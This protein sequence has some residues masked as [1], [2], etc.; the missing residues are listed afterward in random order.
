MSLDDL[1][2]EL[3][4]VGVPQSALNIDMN[5]HT[6]VESLTFSFDKD[7]KKLPIVMIQN[8]ESKVPIPIPIPDITPFDPPL[9]LLGP[10]TLGQHRIAETAKL[11]PLQGIL[12]GLA[13]AAKFSDSVFASG[14]LDVLRYGGVLKSRRLVGVRG[15]GPAYDGL[16]YVS[17]VKHKIKRGEYKQDFELS[18]NGLVS[19]LPRVPA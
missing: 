9:G 13:K 6:N 2:G 11:S 17:S 12:I 15:A 19:T 1:L 7:K 3:W 5:A 10:L 16:Y 18:R 14:S 8:E 4:A